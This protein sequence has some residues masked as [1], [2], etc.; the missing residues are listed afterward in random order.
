MTSA[1]LSFYV[2]LATLVI[3]MILFRLKVGDGNTG[4]FPDLVLNE[5]FK[6]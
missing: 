2:A 5:K 1:I 3:E 4:G 6:G